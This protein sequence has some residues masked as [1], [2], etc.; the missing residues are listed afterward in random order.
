MKKWSEAYREYIKV[1]LSE[2]KSDEREELLR[3][4]FFDDS[5]FDRLG[6]LEKLAI[7]EEEKMYFRLVDACYAGMD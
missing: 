3:A 1:P 2:L 6:E 5:M 4:L 7:S